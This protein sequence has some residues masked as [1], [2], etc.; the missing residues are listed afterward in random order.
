M[1]ISRGLRTNKTKKSFLTRCDLVAWY[2]DW[3]RKNVFCNNIRLSTQYLHGD[4]YSIHQINLYISCQSIIR[5]L[6][7]H[8]HSQHHHCRT[9]AQTTDE[10]D[11]TR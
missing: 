7:H 6:I 10:S 11:A 8:L 3:P 4:H 1:G 5:V 9:R 2:V